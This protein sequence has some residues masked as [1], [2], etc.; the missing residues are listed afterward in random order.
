MSA[1]FVQLLKATN[2]KNKYTAV[3]YDSMRKRIKTV[4][5]GDINY[6]DYTQHQDMV[7]QQS[8]ISRH[9]SREDFNKFMTAGSLSYHLLWSKPTLSSAYK[10]YQKRF[11]LQLF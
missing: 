3:F 1:K 7:R 2:G 6:Q 8:Y 5:F 11:N 4:N 10:A 9:Q